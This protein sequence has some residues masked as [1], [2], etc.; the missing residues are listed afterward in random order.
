MGPFSL[1]NKML[2][3]RLRGF[4]RYEHSLSALEKAC[5]SDFHYLEIDTR[6]SQDGVIYVYHSASTS[7][8][9]TRKINF[10]ETL[11]S[12]VDTV[13]FKNA[14]KILTLEECL[15]AFKSRKNS[16]QRLCLDIK[17]YGFEENHLSL[18][19]KFGLEENVIF[20][21]WI[22]QTLIRLK[23]IGAETPLILSHWNFIKY[24]YVG[25]LIVNFFS[26]KIMS[27]GRYVLLGRNNYNLPLDKYSKGFQHAILLQEI[28]EYLLKILKSSGGGICIHKRMVSKTLLRYCQ[29]SDI[30]L[31][32]FSVSD[33]EEFDKYAKENGIDIVFCD[34]D[35]TTK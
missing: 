5:E 18:V 21:S 12:V 23:E 28:P 26:N 17:D 29:Q 6:V 24:K 1:T 33:K 20:V 3:H 4:S 16:K 22:P 27:I 32:I 31:W 30:Q 19:K 2:S 13:Q 9:M 8:D 11:S 14:E 15:Q 10:A 7:A 25:K 34:V 35:L